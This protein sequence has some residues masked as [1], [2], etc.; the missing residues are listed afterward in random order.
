MDKQRETSARKKE[1]LQER[2]KRSREDISIRALLKDNSC[3]N[4][5]H[6]SFVWLHRAHIA[7]AAA[8]MA[9]CPCQGEGGLGSIGIR[10]ELSDAWQWET[11][12]QLSDMWNRVHPNDKKRTA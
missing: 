12:N 3:T 9:S 1:T 8:Y 11:G 10:R 4:S 6:F 2:G 7:Q 5:S